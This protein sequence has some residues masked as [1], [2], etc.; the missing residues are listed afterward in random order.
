MNDNEIDVS[1]QMG[2]EA[3]VTMELRDV[4]GRTVP[5]ANAK[6]Q[7]EQLGSH[8]ATIPVPNLP[9]GTYY[10]RITTDAGDAIT[11]KVVKE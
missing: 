2:R 11:L 3:L 8:N 9:A 4:L 5:I 6:Y 1:Y 10:L 7:L